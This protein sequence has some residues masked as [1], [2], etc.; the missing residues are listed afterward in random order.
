MTGRPA[1]FVVMPWITAE[2]FE[3]PGTTWP[4][5]VSAAALVRVFPPAVSRLLF[6]SLATYGTWDTS[7]A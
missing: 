3:A 2:I 7:M 6:R 1:A 4:A 5:P